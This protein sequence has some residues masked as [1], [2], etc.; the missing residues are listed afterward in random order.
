M[1]EKE[2]SKRNVGGEIGLS[3][4]TL[5]VGALLLRGCVVDGI[6]SSLDD[7]NDSLQYQQTS[8]LQLQSQDVIGSEEPE[9]FY[10][11]NGKR[12]Y[13]KIDSLQ[14]EEIQVIS[15]YKEK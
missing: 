3:L 2:I 1:N 13:V 10:E 6:Q 11:I 5:V 8:E 14:I 7:I 9:E 4:G 12:A 15:I